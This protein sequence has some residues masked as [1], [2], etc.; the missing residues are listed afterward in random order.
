MRRRGGGAAVGL[1]AVLVAFG[2]CSFALV[3]RAPPGQLWVTE[4]SHERNLARCTSSPVAPIVD[5]AITLGI[6]GGA[7]DVVADSRGGDASVGLAAVMIV[8][9]LVYL[10][11]TLYGFSATNR[12]QDY[13][14]GPPY[15]Y[16]PEQGR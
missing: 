10:A 8:P 16:S 1:L 2:G 9:A 7:V 11:S 5:G 15:P 13:L 12:C 14:D 6:V 4:H 3:D